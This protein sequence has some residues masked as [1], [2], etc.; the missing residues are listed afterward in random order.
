VKVI[1]CGAGQVGFDIARQL[2]AEDNDVTVID[3]DNDRLRK[4]NDSLDVLTLQG[5]ASY[6]DILQ[7]AGAED[8]DMLIAVTQVDEINMVSCQVAHTLFNTPIKIARIRHHAYLEPNWRH[9]FSRDQM[10]IDVIISPEN[11]VVESIGRLLEAPG[12]TDVSSFSEGAV[13]LVGV[14]LN[15][16]CPVVNTPLRQLTE[17]FPDLNI[18][19]V[20][21]IREEEHIYPREMEQLLPKDEIYFVADSKHV[22][23]AMQIF[24]HEEVPAQS[25]VIIGAGNIGLQLCQS[26]EKRLDGI[27]VKLIESNKERAEVVAEQLSSTIVING[28]ALEKE[29]LEE[30]NI[31]TAETI[32]AVSEDDEVN[33]LSSVLAKRYGCSRAVALINETTYAPLVTPLGIDTA[34]SPRDITVSRI[35]EHIRKGKIHS[36]YSLKS[37]NAEI[38]EADAMETAPVIGIPLQDAKLPHGVLVGALVRDNTVIIPRG[39]SII[40][41]GDRVIIFSPKDSIKKVEK[42]FSVAFGYL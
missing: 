35:L 21:I 34:I 23:R 4:I 37:G 16:D 31:G 24:G 29:I 28:D 9:L 12:A 33:I 38:I 40:Q 15:D 13:K 42:L 3:H 6:P 1:V 14:R 25:M 26:I 41:K 30:A 39:Q 17:L 7:L 5:F 22:K 32:I 11:E 19:V 18:T 8:T 20:Y 36:I 2:S 27:S 10:P